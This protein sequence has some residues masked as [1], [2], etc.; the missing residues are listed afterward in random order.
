MSGSERVSWLVG[1]CC[2]EWLVERRMCACVWSGCTPI[3][4]F[5]TRT[6][7][8]TEQGTPFRNATTRHL[9]PP[10]TT[11]HSTNTTPHNLFCAVDCSAKEMFCIIL[12]VGFAKR[13]RFF[14][15]TICKGAKRYSFCPLPLFA[16]GDCRC[17]VSSGNMT[18]GVKY[19]LG[20]RRRAQTKMSRYA[21]EGG[22]SLTHPKP[23]NVTFQI[24]LQGSGFRVWGVWGSGFRECW[25]DLNNHFGFGPAFHGDPQTVSR[26]STVRTSDPPPP[27]KTEKRASTIRTLT[28]LPFHPPNRITLNGL[29]RERKGQS[30]THLQ[31]V[32]HGT[33]VVRH[34]TQTDCIITFW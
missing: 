6:Q 7:P 25:P 13:K 15:L 9:S 33:C 34:N 18:C 20:G 23:Y 2:K 17:A 16:V 10:F 28:P 4:P 8:F 31:T 32:F 5:T 3:S 19:G 22:Q 29:G 27:S 24:R 14:P 26:G 1:E 11:L 30:L 12:C 21:G